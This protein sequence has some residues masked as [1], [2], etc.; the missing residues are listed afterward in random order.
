MAYDEDRPS[1]IQEE[2]TDRY[3]NEGEHDTISPQR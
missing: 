2:S 1:P 3:H